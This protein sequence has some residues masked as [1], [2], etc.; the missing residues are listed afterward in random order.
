MDFHAPAGLAQ[1][2]PAGAAAKPKEVRR[3]YFKEAGDFLPTPVHLCSAGEEAPEEPVN[4]GR[5]PWHGEATENDYVEFVRS[6][7]DVE[8]LTVRL[9]V[10]STLV[11]PTAIA[12][13]AAVASPAT[14]R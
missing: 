13:L 7:F 14:V 6:R 3:V 8:P 12:R 2:L 4:R 5:A 11:E 1:A 9:R 10:S